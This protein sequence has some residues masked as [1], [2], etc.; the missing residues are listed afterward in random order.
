M[1]KF[2]LI[3]QREYITRVTSK[4]F[5]LSTLLTPIGFAVFSLAATYILSYKGGNERILVKDDTHLLGNALRP[6]QSV[7]IHFDTLH[8][9]DTLRLRYA[10]MGYSGIV[11]LDKAPDPNATNVPITYYASKPIGMLTKSFLEDRIA[12]K[13]KDTRIKRAGYNLDT[14]RALSPKVALI[15]KNADP[16]DQTNNNQSAELAS[17]L[18][19]IIGILM[20]AIIF[21]YGNMVMRSVMEEKT[22]RIVEVIISS[23]KPFQLMA[24]KIIGVGAVGITQLIAWA[25]LIPL[26]AMAVTALTGIADPSSMSQLQ[27]Q[28]NEA[29]A[30]TPANTKITEIITTLFSQNWTLIVPLTLFYFFCGYLLYASLF[31]ALGSAIGDDMGEAQTLTLP[32]TLPVIFALY[33]MLAVVQ[34]P[35]SNLA[36]WSSIFPFFSPIV[37]PARLF[38]APPLWQVALSCITLLATCIF[39]AWLSGRIY[40]VGILLYG[41]KASFKELGKWLFYRD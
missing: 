36:T 33:I 2:W 28:L 26:T 35:E 17:I 39:M 29:T 34:N 16:N 25:I 14:L 38:F 19:T 8:S 13:I 22:N 40:R 20:Y 12:E 37:M 3:L 21:I 23:V 18:G 32:I 31:A 9:I 4:S 27:G 5:I 7:A 41:K 10:Q 24:G 1:L 30:N 6:S 11:H 15:E